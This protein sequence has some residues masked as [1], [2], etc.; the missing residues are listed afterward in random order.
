MTE[1][2]NTRKVIAVDFDGVLCTERWPEIGEERPEVIQAALREQKAGAALILWTCRT[3]A[4]LEAA[5]KWCAA[6]GLRFDAVNANIPERVELY[7]NDCRKVGADEYWDDRAMKPEE[8]INTEK[9][10]R[11]CD[12]MKKLAR[13]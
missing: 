9:L 3:G 8:I 11:I 5:V 6:R 13:R 2:G 12:E 1:G 10:M 7:G 4:D